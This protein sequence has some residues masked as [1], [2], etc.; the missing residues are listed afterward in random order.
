[1]GL[2]QMLGLI[3]TTETLRV[4][5]GAEALLVFL[6]MRLHFCHVVQTCLRSQI[7]VIV[8]LKLWPS[9]GLG[10]HSARAIAP[11]TQGNVKPRETTNKEINNEANNKVNNKSDNK[12]NN[13]ANNETSN[14]V[15]NE[16]N[17]KT[18]NQSKNKASNTTRK[19]K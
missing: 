3:V 8:C 12:A 7:A 14:K 19:N 16:V 18:D 13:K 11:G 10:E 17:N 5:T 2:D 15:N 1:M 9:S 4:G 6:K